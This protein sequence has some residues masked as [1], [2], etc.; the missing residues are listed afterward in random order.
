MRQLLGIFGWSERQ[1]RA[2]VGWTVAERVPGVND[3][4]FSFLVRL[5]I[6]GGSGGNGRGYTPIGEDVTTCTSSVSRSCRATC[7]SLSSPSS[8]GFPMPAPRYRGS[9]GIDWCFRKDYENH[10]C[11][12]EIYRQFGEVYPRAITIKE[13]PKCGVVISKCKPSILFWNVG[14]GVCHSNSFIIGALPLLVFI[15]VR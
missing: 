10:S 1:R 2:A 13:I 4:S 9:R 3:G 14:A 6:V 5:F 8:W 7:S 15:S 12:E 11:L